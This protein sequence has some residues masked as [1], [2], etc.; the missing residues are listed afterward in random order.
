M[1]GLEMDNQIKSEMMAYYDSVLLNL[2]G[3]QYFQQHVLEQNAYSPRKGAIAAR[4]TK[5]CSRYSNRA[6][7]SKTTYIYSFKRVFCPTFGSGSQQYSRS[8]TAY[9]SRHQNMLALH[10]HSSVLS[11]AMYISWQHWLLWQ[12]NYSSHPIWDTDIRS[13]IR[14]VSQSH[15]TVILLQF[16]KPRTVYSHIL[17]VLIQSNNNLRSAAYRTASTGRKV[18]TV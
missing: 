2:W 3:H 10:S 13:T 9:S 14:Q 6:F 1:E 4:I 12:Q 18:A 8:A 11:V 15:F 17:T 7:S 5:T 16:Q